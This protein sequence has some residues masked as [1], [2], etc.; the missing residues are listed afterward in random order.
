M[1]GETPVS[2]ASVGLGGYARS[3]LDLV[4]R[5]SAAP[6]PPVK[7][8]AVFEPDLPAHAALVHELRSHGIK[9]T[10]RFDE[11]LSLPVEGVL[12][13][14]PIDLH[15]AYT[16]QALRAGKAVLC[17]KPAAGCVD[18]CDAMIAA[19]DAAKRPVLIGFQDVYDPVI[20]EAK[21]ALLN[22]HIGRIRF[23]TFRAC[24]PRDSGYFTRASW[25]GR[26]KRDGVWVM[27]SPAANA[28]SHFIHLTM[29]LLGPTLESSAVPQRVDAELYRANDIEN[30]DTCAIRVDVGGPTA[31]FCMTHASSV[32]VDPMIV[33]RGEHGMIEVTFSQ[34]F[35][36]N[37][38]GTQTIPRASEARTYMV[39]AFAD[40]IRGRT[41][42][43]A[44][45]T[46]E[47]A[48]VHLVVVNG[49]SEASA[50]H[51]VPPEFVE[52]QASREGAATLRCIPG[53][54]TFFRAC[55]HDNVM[56]HESGKVAW[57]SPAGSIDVRHYA[58]FNG[59]RLE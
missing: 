54:D 51:D 56:P 52:M 42:R 30:Y 25:A 23:A 32:N 55:A 58:H 47:M 17:E 19:R 40:V 11:L 38:G 7:L 59:P 9:V 18:D 8:E 50:I 29:Y 35:L 6:E 20:V 21:K 27:D 53:I 37:R 5:C 16:E 36:R 2:V 12:L 1:S 22:S 45:G 34:V 14:V 46:L 3:I 39:Q 48:R 28:L 24:W 41:P 4:Q 57:T 31:M 43:T 26:F 44:V 10:D 33:I 49:A 15:R 13:P